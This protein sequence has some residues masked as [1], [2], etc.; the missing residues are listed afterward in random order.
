MCNQ[1]PLTT[2]LDLAHARSLFFPEWY[3]CLGYN[4][5]QVENLFVKSIF[6]DVSWPRSREVAFF[7]QNGI[8][9]LAITH[10][11]VENP[12][13]VHKLCTFIIVFCKNCS[14]KKIV[15]FL[16]SWSFWNKRTKWKREDSN[17]R[18]TITIP[19]TLP[20]HWYCSPT[21]HFINI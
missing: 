15:F 10:T 16:V 13:F 17:P 9:V 18:N 11:R 2:C 12:I 5:H 20:L 4:S 8:P 19:M 3:P 7:F 1:F 6:I 14:T 21:S